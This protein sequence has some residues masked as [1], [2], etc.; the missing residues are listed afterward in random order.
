MKRFYVSRNN[1]KSGPYALDEILAKLSTRQVD[2]VDYV[3]DGSG[4]DWVLMAEHPE[5]IKHVKSA[6]HAVVPE[7]PSEHDISEWFV[8][9]GEQRF[10]P[11]GYSDM[12]RMLQ[13]KIIFGFDFAWHGGLSGWK[14]VSDIADFQESA[15]RGL[16]KDRKLA[17]EVFVARKYPRHAHKGKV[18]IH[19]QKQWWSGQVSEISAGGVGIHMDNSLAVPGQQIYLHFKPHERFPSFNATGEIVNKKYI[20]DVKRAIPLNYGIRFLSVSGA[21]KDRLLEL[22]KDSAA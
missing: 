10:G 2:L 14:R 18:I 9:K 7:K 22:L 3:H 21:G 12:I 13:E 20:E 17:R 4:K 1:Q 11:F 19:D 16:L 8:M 5:I 15:I 6:R